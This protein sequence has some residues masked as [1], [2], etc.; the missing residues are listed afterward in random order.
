M[1]A[2]AALESKDQIN[3]V[4]SFLFKHYSM[5]MVDAW[6]IGL[7]TALRVSD[8]LSLKYDDVVMR[9]AKPT[10]ELR[11]GKT[12]KSRLIHL[13]AK[14]YDIIK[15]RKRKNVG[16]TYIFQSTSNNMKNK[17]PKPI[18]REGLARALKEAGEQ[19]DLMMP[20][21]TH[22]MRKTRGLAVYRQTNDI[23]L[24]MT[25]LNHTSMESTLRY[26]GVTGKRIE[27]TYDLV[28]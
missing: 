23:A 19:P 4:T 14:A 6:R 12:G 15:A 11:E 2:V 13:N 8:L 22:T 25:L 26:L 7:Q 10:V 21:S 20:L 28:L 17:A 27:E 3:L 16:H 9:A 1:K 24:V 18:S 5:T